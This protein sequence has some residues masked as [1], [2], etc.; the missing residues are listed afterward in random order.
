MNKM[1]LTI[2]RILIVVFM[3]A[4]L[5]S[6]AQAEDIKSRMLKRLPEI[7]KLKRQGLIGENNRGYLEF[8]SSQKKKQA[9]I[10]SE[11]KDRRNIYSRI[12]GQHNTPLQV[13]EKH[14]AARIEKNARL[15]EWL[16]DAAG[17]WYQKK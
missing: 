12:A 10:E 11:N 1:Y 5:L 2:I 13:V 14:R 3:T 6:P 17:K 8:V 4:V 7:K 15:G 9:L 16:Q